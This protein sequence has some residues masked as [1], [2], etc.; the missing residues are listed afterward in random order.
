M[1]LQLL[2]H[3]LAYQFE[4]PR[5]ALRLGIE[6]LVL[7]LQMPH[8]ARGLRQLLTLHREFDILLSALDAQHIHPSVHQQIEHHSPHGHTYYN[9]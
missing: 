1:T 2:P 5:L 8:P 4:F 3:L 7:S 6:R 9:I